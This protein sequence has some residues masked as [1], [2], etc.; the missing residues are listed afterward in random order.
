MKLEDEIKQTKP[1]SDEGKKAIVN[2]LYTANAIADRLTVVLKPYNINDQH[3]NVLRILKGKYPE[4]VCPGDIK[5]VL[6]NKRG[7]LTRLLDKLE[8]KGWVNRETNATNRR[9]VDVVITKEGLEMIHK[10]SEEVGVASEF[11]DNL[12]EEEAFQLNRLL[13]KLRN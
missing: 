11:S 4:P 12:T 3:F 9:M 6:I 8:K 1:F 7:D 10:M 5:E 2:I 13:D